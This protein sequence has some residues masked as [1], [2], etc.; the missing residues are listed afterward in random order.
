MCHRP[1]EYPSQR[2]TLFFLDR[3]LIMQ[4]MR[5]CWRNKS[6]DCAQHEHDVLVVSQCKSLCFLTISHQVR[7]KLLTNMHLR[8]ILLPWKF[9]YNNRVNQTSCLLPILFLY[10]C[11]LFQFF[12]LKRKN[13]LFQRLD[14]ACCHLLTQLH[15]FRQSQAL[16]FTQGN[17]FLR[18]NHELIRFGVDILD[19]CHSLYEEAFFHHTHK[20][21][22]CFL[23]LDPTTYA[24]A[25]DPY[26][27]MKVLLTL[28]GF[29]LH[30][31]VWQG[32]HAALWLWL[33][34]VKVGLVCP[35]MKVLTKRH[36]K[37]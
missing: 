1:S 35:P 26:S 17:H 27:C 24:L 2:L 13:V 23:L 3:L 29:Y 19:D 11:R 33:K 5:H 36:Y 37:N 8:L 32:F 15:H 25:I 4:L 21:N 30:S 6:H 12:L 34:W 20:N 7:Y 10:C 16:S 18:D 9:H 31:F 14:N 28:L 22:S